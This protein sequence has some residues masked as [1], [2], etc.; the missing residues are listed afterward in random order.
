MEEQE[1]TLPYM[2]THQ[3]LI[4]S[5]CLKISLTPK[6]CAS[7]FTV[8]LENLLGNEKWEIPS[9]PPT[10]HWKRITEM[11]EQA[12]VAIVLGFQRGS[13]G[14]SCNTYR[15]NMINKV[16]SGGTIQH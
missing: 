2:W 16:F 7:T 8:A 3:L 13:L 15:A 1:F 14:G 11:V 12:C 4:M 6:I 9:L 5:W 10:M